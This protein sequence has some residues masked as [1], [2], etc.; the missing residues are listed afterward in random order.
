MS[1]RQSRGLLTAGFAVAAG[2]SV[3]AMTFLPN[4][5]AKIGLL[6][7][8]LALTNGIYPLGFAMVGEI[9]PTRQRGAVLAIFSAV[10][11]TAGLLAPTVMGYA[12]EL[13]ST[14]ESGFNNGFLITSALLLA[15]GLVG[16]LLIDPEGDRVR[17]LR[18]KTATGIMPARRVVA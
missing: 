12:V 11:T 8:G 1:S 14:P 6:V 16:L 7:V 13:G 5:S 9:V 2:L 18:Q 10:F 17:L 3:C 15:A 4:A